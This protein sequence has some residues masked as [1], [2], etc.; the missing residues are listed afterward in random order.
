MDSPQTIESRG[1]R[2]ATALAIAGVM[3]LAFALRIIGIRW[4]M[5]DAT[6]YYSYHPDEIHVLLPVQNICLRGDLNPH[7]FNYGSLYIYLVALVAKIGHLIGLSPFASPNLGPLHVLG[8]MVTVLLGTATVYLVYLI[9][10]E[11][12]GRWA[13][14]LSALFLAITPLHIIHSHY[15]TVDVAGTFWLALAFLMMLKLLSSP[16]LKWY[17]LAGMSIGFAAATKYNLA[18]ALLPLMVA[19]FLVWG[20]ESVKSWQ[21]P[22][23]AVGTTLVAFLIAC[24]YS[25]LDYAEFKRD[26]LFEMEH[27]RIGGTYAF[28]GMGSG[29]AYHVLHSFPWGLGGAL[30]ALVLVGL[31]WSIWRR[32]PADLVIW[33]WVLPYFLVIGWAKEM[34][35]RYTIPLLPFFC[36]WAGQLISDQYRQAM[37]RSRGIP[38]QGRRIRWATMVCVLVIAL[39]TLLFSLANLSMFVRPDPRTQAAN[40]IRNKVELGASI[41]LV[42]IPWY[43]TPPICPENG[44]EFSRREYSKWLVTAPYRLVVTGWDAQRLLQAQ[45]EFFIISD[46]EYRDLVRLGNVG[47]IS[48]LDQLRRSYRHRETFQ[49]P[50]SIFGF[51]V[52]TVTAPPDWLY[53]CPAISVFH[54][55]R[56]S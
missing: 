25:V 38:R 14:L 13:G 40:W 48:L 31:I 4:G 36:L 49:R 47:A 3:A 1:N 45:P 5:P 6:H 51:R 29:W 32:Q 53:P 2:I 19:H 7:F 16:K 18:L 43:F 46:L 11:L 35:I 22:I 34:F 27:M 20:K 42:Y 9:G 56:G 24:P 33:A 17:L 15:A 30:L 44:G 12:G 8:R 39:A 50:P 37:V 54:N 10:R 55:G 41:G 26:F 23:V 28:V 21:R 52:R